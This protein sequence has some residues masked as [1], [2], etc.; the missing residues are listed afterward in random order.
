MSVKSNPSTSRHCDGS[1][2]WA[3][4]CGAACGLT[5]ARIGGVLTTSI[6]DVAVVRLRL[7]VPFRG[8]SAREVLL[9]RGPVGW[10]EFAPFVEYDD[11]QSVAWWRAM[12]AAGERRWPAPRRL[13]VPVNATVPAVP[14]TQVRAVLALFPGCATAKVKVAEAGH[15][16]GEDLDR[17]AAVR[18]A[19]GP[20]GRIRI[21]VNAAWP[22]D[23]ARRRL[24]RYDAAAGGWSTSSS[25]V[26][27]TDDLRR[28]YAEPSTWPSRPTSPF[29]SAPTPARPPRRSMSWWSRSRRWVG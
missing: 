15:T 22:L 3:G 12:R 6:G 11:Q 16:E 7:R 14:A 19:L 4:G 1:N 20:D 8:L 26:P 24:P 28:D 10:G 17:L 18:D 23:E 13:T 25:R 21:D 2:G 27:S 9:W 5:R 29:V